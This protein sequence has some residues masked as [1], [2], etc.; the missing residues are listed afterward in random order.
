MYVFKICVRIHVFSLPFSKVIFKA[1]K[2]CERLFL[3]WM[4]RPVCC[5]LSTD[6]NTA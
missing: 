5:Y 3:S 1:K 4:Q 2:A 6:G